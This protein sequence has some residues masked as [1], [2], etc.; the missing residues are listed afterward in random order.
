MFDEDYRPGEIIHI[1]ASTQE[2]LSYMLNSYTPLLIEQGYDW[3]IV[4]EGEEEQYEG[5][6]DLYMRIKVIEP[7][8]NNLPEFGR[9]LH[10]A[11]DSFLYTVKTQCLEG[12]LRFG[13]I[14]NDLRVEYQREPTAILDYFSITLEDLAE[15]CDKGR[16]EVEEISKSLKASPEYLMRVLFGENVPVF[17]NEEITLEEFLG[18]E[19]DEVTEPH[20]G[21]Q[22]KVRLISSHPN[23]IHCDQQ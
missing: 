19:L 18:D 8:E 10:H 2:E 15:I 14:I 21:E 7:T 4:S 12:D 16:S 3:E 1:A 5:L 9:S 23:Y 17:E 11:H 22:D 20:S 13:E 6:L